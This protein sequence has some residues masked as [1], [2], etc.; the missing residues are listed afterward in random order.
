MGSGDILHYPGA[1]K[2]PFLEGG[3]SGEQDLICLAIFLNAISEMGFVGEAKRNLVGHYRPLGIFLRS[4][5]Q[6]KVEVADAKMPDLAIADKL[7]QRTKGLG[8]VHVLVRPVDEV[9]IKVIHLQP[10]KTRFTGLEDLMIGQ[11]RGQ[12]FG[13]DEK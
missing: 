11:V 7:V 9:K 3:V 10:P 5:K 8:K 6:R 13:C 2:P 12:Y 1:G 4:F